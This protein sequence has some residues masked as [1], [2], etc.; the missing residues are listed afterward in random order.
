MLQRSMGTVVPKHCVM[1]DGVPW[2]SS[3][4]LVGFS[5]VIQHCGNEAE[6]WLDRRT[7]TYVLDEAERSERR[8]EC[9]CQWVC[10][11][12][13]SVARAPLLTFTT[14]ASQPSATFTPSPFKVK[15]K[16]PAARL[17]QAQTNSWLTLCHL[18]CHIAGRVH[19]R[20]RITLNPFLCVCW[21]HGFC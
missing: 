11:P 6:L 15:K 14:G 10:V 4:R 13:A 5:R 12:T 18:W 17:V 3:R 20:H 9:K 21:F 8:R 2:C 7:C 16:S 1:T 19:R